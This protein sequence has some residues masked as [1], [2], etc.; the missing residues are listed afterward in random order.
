MYHDYIKELST[1]SYQQEVAK[2]VVTSRNE[3]LH[4]PSFAFGFVL[5][6]LF[7]GFY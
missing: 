4:Y 3:K 7:I 2:Q 5:A 6:S 1:K